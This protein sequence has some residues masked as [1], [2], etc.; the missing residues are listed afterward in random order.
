MCLRLGSS[1]ETCSKVGVA[2]NLFVKQWIFFN[3]TV[4]LSRQVK[5]N[6]WFL[7]SNVG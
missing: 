6:F 7:L 5:C 1:T 4:I 3:L 2:H